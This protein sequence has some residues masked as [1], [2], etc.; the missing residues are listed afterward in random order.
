MAAASGTYA[1][2]LSPEEPLAPGQYLT[3]A[4]ALSPRGERSPL[5]DARAAGAA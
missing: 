1:G 2:A 3:Q 4:E 5:G